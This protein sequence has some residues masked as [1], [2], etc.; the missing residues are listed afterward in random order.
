M[1]KVSVIIVSYN[2][3]S[4]IAHSIESIISSKYENIEIIVIDNNSYDG[5][6]DYLKNEYNDKCDI[7]IIRNKNNIGFGKAINKAAKIANGDYFFI[8][9]PDT[10]IEEN[11]ISILLDYLIYAF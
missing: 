4:Y 10:I 8:L 9:N 11:T 6:C 3:R 1:S 5:T 7:K 2:V